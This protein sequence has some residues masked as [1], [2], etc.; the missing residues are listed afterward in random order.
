MSDSEQGDGPSLELPSFG[1]GR[2]KKKSQK[3]SPKPSKPAAP[4]EPGAEELPPAAAPKLAHEQPTDVVVPVPRGGYEALP[5]PRRCCAASCRP[6]PQVRPCRRAPAAA[7][8]LEA[9]ILR[10]QPTPLFARRGRARQP[11]GGARRDSRREGRPVALAAGPP[12]AWHECRGHHR[13]GRRRRRGGAHRGLPAPV[14]DRGRDNSCGGPGLLLL[15]VILAGLVLLGSSMLALFE[16]TD[17]R[18]TSFLAVGLLA[19]VV[20][21][22]LLGVMFRRRWWSSCL[23][24]VG[25]RSGIIFIGLTDVRRTIGRT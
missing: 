20:M 1:F 12:A 6:A 4:P 8:G 13:C 10:D 3:P 22:F 21:L 14:P 15:L 7:P 24:T 2:Q 19:V 25:A 23:L 16:V 17:P 11:R 9:P 18:G 5:S